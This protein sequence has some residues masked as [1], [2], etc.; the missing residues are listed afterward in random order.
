M[1][2]VYS[3]QL[4]D[5]I[6]MPVIRGQA[7]RRGPCAEMQRVRPLNDAHMIGR[8]SRC[9]SALLLSCHRRRLTPASGELRSPRPNSTVARFRS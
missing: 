8:L 6:F 7:C 1:W 5:A 3:W 2:R 4:Q 9:D